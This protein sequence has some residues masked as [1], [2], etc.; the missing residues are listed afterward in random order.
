M[1]NKSK[2]KN[3]LVPLLKLNAYAEKKAILDDMD[4]ATMISNLIL[5]MFKVNKRPILNFEDIEKV[6]PYWF[7]LC[8]YKYIIKMGSKVNDF[9]GIVNI[10]DTQLKV[11]NIVTKECQKNGVAILDGIQTSTLPSDEEDNL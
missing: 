6:H 11:L 8:L 7:V 5:E 9:I 3:K 4:N 2:L 10:S 1:V